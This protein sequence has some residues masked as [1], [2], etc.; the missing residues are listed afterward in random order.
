MPANP[1]PDPPPRAGEG[2]H[3]GDSQRLD[4]W[5]WAARFFKTRSRAA[6]YVSEG[7]LR[8]DGRHI[9]KPAQS[10]R[11]GAVLT[12]P[13]GTTIRVV[14]VAGLARRR[15]PAPE[16]RQLYEDLAASPAS[17]GSGS[18]VAAEEE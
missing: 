13:L 14:R 9:A 1:H 7:R 11:I 6:Q 15:G 18:G 3:G 2:A 5:L 8:L 16:A 10:V 17:L 12:F 4:V